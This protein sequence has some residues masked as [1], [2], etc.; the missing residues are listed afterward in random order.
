[1]EGE[2]ALAHI[3]QD[4]GPAGQRWLRGDIGTNRY[5]RVAVG[6][7][8]VREDQGAKLLAEPGWISPINGPEPEAAMGRIRIGI[9]EQHFSR[10]QRFA[11]LM[12][13]RAAD[14]TGP[15]VS[16]IVEMRANLGSPGDAVPVPVLPDVPVPMPVLPPH[17]STPPNAEPAAASPAVPMSLGQL[18]RYGHISQVTS[19]GHTQR[20][21]H[22][23]RWAVPQRSQAMFL[24]AL[25]A[26]LISA[27]GPALTSA[28]P[29]LI[30]GL[31]PMAGDLL[32][33]LLGGLGGG[34]GGHAA[35]RPSAPN[36]P[37]G[38]PG[39][40]DTAALTTLIQNLIASAGAPPRAA[41]PVTVGAGAAARADAAT[42]SSVRRFA[43]QAGRRR[44]ALAMTARLRRRQAAM[45][46]C[47]GGA[48]SRGQMSHAQVV[49]IAL[50]TQLMPLLQNVL[51]P[52]TVQSVINMPNQHMQT[53]FNAMRDAGRLGIESHEQDLAHLRAI[54]PGVDD[55]GFDAL[56]AGLGRGLS[57]PDPGAAWQRANGVVLS[58]TDVVTVAV[59]GRQVTLLSAAHEL[60][61][62][63]AVTLPAAADGSTPVIADARVQ[64][65]VKDQETL[66][67]LHQQDW[68]VGQIAASGALAVVPRVA[69]GA[70]SGVPVGRDLLF[71]FTLLWS[72]R[73]GKARGAPVQH[74]ARLADAVAFDRLEESGART[75]LDDETRFGDYMHV[76]WSNRFRS[77][78]RRVLGELVYVAALAQ[79]GA[80]HRRLETSQ[81]SAGVERTPSRREV[82]LNSGMEFSIDT[83]AA[84][85][86]M[87]DPAAPA[88]D[89]AMRA[90]LDD[91]AFAAQFQRSTRI[92]FDF[93][94][95]PDDTFR[96]IA[97]PVMASMLAHFATVDSVDDFGQVRT[98]GRR[99]AMLPVPVA[100]NLRVEPMG[101]A[102][103]A[104]PLFAGVGEFAPTRLVA[105]ATS[106]RSKHGARRGR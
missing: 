100:L 92:S 13:Y 90:A 6:D 99:S 77:D 82:R 102:P 62:P 30:S 104:E 4:D 1:M 101:D 85:G 35:P 54:N 46:V 32:G 12:S 48:A 103:D 34:G 66:E 31:A 49:P 27:V 88:M 2:V 52:E 25:L 86:A 79:E 29:G 14:G 93:R 94:G 40:I 58:L 81:Q 106:R 67:I 97:A 64:L 26:P 87:L 59:A 63:L 51:T 43:G 61:F 70:L 10:E 98:L 39:T 69:A 37:A 65:Q 95:T 57:R 8:A 23:M 38:S 56:L 5:W 96:M 11:Q 3:V 72:N 21:V 20:G 9:D 71:C 24:P 75:T 80:G 19:F 74:L 83:L 50:L 7:G 55:P 16:A 53:V 60:A 68:P 89:T 78:A 44:S 28:L 84:L 105:I 76:V 91:A 36:P 73:Q 45:S 18:H 41:A 22:A 47:G 15:A 17:G 33:G 42:T